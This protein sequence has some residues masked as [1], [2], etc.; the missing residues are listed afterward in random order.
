MNKPEANLDHACSVKPVNYN[1]SIHTLE[2]LGEWSY[3]GRVKIALEINKS[4]KEIVLNTNQLKIHSAELSTEHTKTETASKASNIEYDAP[5]QRATLSFDDEFPVTQKA[6]LDISFQG[7]INNVSAEL[8][9]AIST[10]Y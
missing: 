6:V 9:S 10:Q 3:Q 5:R 4:A 1:L 7:T 8:C 2:F